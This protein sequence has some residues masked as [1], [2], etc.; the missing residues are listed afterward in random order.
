[1]AEKARI[2]ATSGAVFKRLQIP[3]NGFKTLKKAQKTVFL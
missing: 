1:M 3:L 2:S